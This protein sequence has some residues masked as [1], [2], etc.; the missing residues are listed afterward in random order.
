MGIL[1]GIFIFLIGLSIGSFINVLIYRVPKG[2][3][4]VRPS[5]YC[6]QC[7]HSLSWRDNI[8]L[9]SYVYL[10]GKCRYCFGR[11][12]VMY[13]LTEFLTGILFVALYMKFGI[14]LL[15]IKYVVFIFL[16]LVVSLTDIYTSMDDFETGM[17]P[18]IYLVIGLGFG[19]FFG[20]LEGGL[21]YYLA[22]ISAGYLVLFFPSYIYL[23]VRHREG[24]GEGDFIFFGMIGSFTGLGSVPA[25]LTISS[26]FGI[27][28][29]LVIILLTKD[30]EYPIPFA[31]MLG[32]SAIIYVFFEDML[33]I[34][35][36]VNRF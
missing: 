36:L 13:P 7:N 26:F 31:P 32:A 28:S 14:S 1:A 22:G 2:L 9:I 21:G 5:S 18:V 12:S 10:L 30:R 17:I 24:M 8:P 29:G 6:P 35:N 33:N 25:I 3:S 34:Y 4:I 11:I 16:I 27:L 15:F 23:K 20:I 19:I